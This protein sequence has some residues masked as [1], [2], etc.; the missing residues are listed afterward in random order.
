MIATIHQF[1]I[2]S[3]LFWFVCEFLSAFPIMAAQQ[4]LTTRTENGAAAVTAAGVMARM[5]ANGDRGGA[6]V[7]LNASLSGSRDGKMLEASVGGTH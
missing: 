7:V 2:S 6:L 1:T 5:Q 4:P 3:T